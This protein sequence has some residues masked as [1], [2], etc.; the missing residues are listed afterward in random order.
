MSNSLKILDNEQSLNGESPFLKPLKKDNNAEHPR[1]LRSLSKIIDGGLCHRCGSCVGICPTGVLSLDSESYP[2]VENLS[3]C[4]D[5]DLCV[6]VCPGDEL[7]LVEHYKEFHGKEPE[8]TNTHGDFLEAIIGYSNYHGLREGSTSGGIVTAVLLHM[9]E[10]KQIDGAVVIA[11]DP[12]ALWRGKPIIA[13]TKEEILS[14]VKSKYAISPTNS[15]FKE[16]RE[17]KG[18][19][20]LVGLPCQIHGYH[21][22]AALDKKLKERVVLTVGLF[23]HAAI[24][25]EAFRVIWDSLGDKVNGAK[26]FVSRVGKHPGSPQ[27]ELADGS[28]YPVYFG[29]KQGFK[30]SSMEIINV[31]YRLYTPKRCLTCFDALSEMAD[32]SVGDPWMAPPEDDV[33]FH[34]GWSFALIRSKR[35]QA[36]IKEMREADLIHARDLTHKEAKSCNHE[37]STEKRWR[38]FRM[39]ETQKRQGKSI[40]DYG[41]FEVPR[42]TGKKF[43]TTERNIFTHILCFVPSFRKPVLKFFL[44]NGGYIILWLNNKRRNLKFYIRDNYVRIK[45]KYSGRK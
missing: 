23:C 7:N 14:A 36:A 21:K 26:S 1:A 6:K 19:Y 40:P 2:K 39:I 3:S 37:M 4:T 45:R 44:G 16:I 10:T 12:E 8:L 20:A 32:I 18:K 35:G 27:L 28:F 41:N 5:C 34:Q 31:L 22:A 17:V 11:S 42:H 13:R 38:A 33:D 43:L 29:N 25:H 30:P 24:E 15:V 9:L